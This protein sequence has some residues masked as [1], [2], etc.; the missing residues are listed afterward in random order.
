MAVYER[1]K[2]PRFNG[3]FDAIGRIRKFMIFMSFN[4][5]LLRTI[6]AEQFQCNYNYVLQPTSQAKRNTKKKVRCGDT[7]SDFPCLHPINFQAVTINVVKPFT[8]N[9]RAVFLKFYCAKTFRL[10]HAATV[11][12]VS[13]PRRSLVTVMR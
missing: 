3:W 10:L 5:S 9:S 6:K 8:S 4:I 13:I 2:I 11:G 1:G 12:D 7:K